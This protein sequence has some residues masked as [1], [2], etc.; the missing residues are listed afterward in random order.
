[1]NVSRIYGPPH[2]PE[3]VVLDELADEDV[4]VLVYDR[5]SSTS[6]PLLSLSIFRLLALARGITGRWRESTLVLAGDA[7]RQA[8]VRHGEASPG[9]DVA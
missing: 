1:L 4:V 3:V 9:R 8:G 2:K 7:S 6:W 5:L